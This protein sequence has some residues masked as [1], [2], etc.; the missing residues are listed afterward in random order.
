MSNPNILMLY[1]DAIMWITYCNDVCDRT[2]QNQ[3]EVGNSEMARNPLEHR[4]V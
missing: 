4:E 3:A 1:P 2:Y